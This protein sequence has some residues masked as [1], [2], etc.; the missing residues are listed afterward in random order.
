MRRRGSRIRRRLAL[1]TL[2]VLAAM[3]LAGTTPARADPATPPPG[4]PRGVDACTFLPSFAKTICQAAR[5]GNP[6]K[7]IVQGVGGAI[8]SGIGGVVGD[9]GLSG[10]TSWTGAAAVFVAEK[11]LSLINYVASPNLNSPA[12]T[13][14]YHIAIALAPPVMV[15]MCLVALIAAAIHRD[16]NTIG[17]M[18]AA[19]LP[20]VLLTVASPAVLQLLIGA[21]DWAS[22]VVMHSTGTDIAN[23]MNRIVSFFGQG[24]NPQ[25]PGLVILGTAV[26][27]L[28]GSVGIFIDLVVRTA[29]IYLAVATLPIAWAAIVYRPAR[30]WVRKLVR[31]L[32]AVILSKFFVIFGFAVAAKLLTAAGFGL[33]DPFQGVVIGGGFMLVCAFL[34]LL[35]VR[36]VGAVDAEIMNRTAVAAAV[37]HVPLVASNAAQ[38]Q[39]Q[40]RHTV[41]LRHL[42]NQLTGQGSAAAKGATG[43]AA[44]GAGAA[45]GG[46]AAAGVGA[47][48][49]AAGAAKR[50]ASQATGAA[51]AV[52][53]AP[54]GAPTAPSAAAPAN[55]PAIPDQPPQPPAWTRI[56]DNQQRR[57]FYESPG[58]KEIPGER[59]GDT[60]DKPNPWPAK[61][62]KPRNDTTRGDGSDGS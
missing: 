9:V 14:A 23:F 3:L 55:L 44:K 17:S 19:I 15:I 11:I 45:A 12:F 52:L 32:I 33:R 35:L 43:A 18:L 40:L 48:A 21:V 25:V 61:Y 54:G 37:R 7:G 50:R 60:Y 13:E 46:A 36:L 22:A 24:N 62:F 57:V 38:V 56:V 58:G 2:A 10:L 8:G 34:P 41:S 42:S 49:Q 4:G 29:L 30:N 16:F 20:A 59:F 39:S 6:V 1:V 5:G 53:D 26:V 47:A 31:L 27:V 51:T 28:I